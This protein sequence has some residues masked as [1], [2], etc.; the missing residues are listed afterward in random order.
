MDLRPIERKDVVKVLIVKLS[1]LGDV[2][3]AMP[4][5]QDLRRAFTG[6]QIDWVVERAFAPLVARCDGVQRVIACDL[7]RW[8][9]APFSKTTRLE[10]AAFK[11]ELQADAYDAVIDLQG[12][13]KSAPGVLAG[14][15]R[16]TRAALRPGQP[17]RWLQFRSTGALG[18]RR[19]H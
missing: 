9:K 13:T 3:H 16:S 2:V 12:L 18:G 15:H 8:R 1:S 7:R 4:A 14:P 6:V 17:N 11:T 19:G 10:W 5:V